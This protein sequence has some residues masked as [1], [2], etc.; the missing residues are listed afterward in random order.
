M[1][2]ALVSASAKTRA[3]LRRAARIGAHELRGSFLEVESALESLR[4][5]PPEL[6]VLEVGAIEGGALHAT[7]RLVDHVGCPLLLLARSDDRSIGEVSRALAAGAVD[8]VMLPGDAKAEQAMDAV[9]AKLRTM[10]RLTRRGCGSA[11]GT[12]P[13][14]REPLRGPAPLV[15]IGASTGGPQALAAVLSDLP[16]P[17]GG[18]VIAALHIDRA[19]GSALASWLGETAGLPCRFARGGER[20]AVGEVRIAAA[21]EHLVLGAD[22]ALDYRA[23]PSGALHRPSI[24]VLFGSLAEHA[25]GRGV[26]VLLTGM[27]R[28]G[29]QGLK[30]LR[31]R[32]WLTITQDEA[33]STVY[34]M[35]RA[36]AQIGAACRVLPLD[37]I[38]EAL[39]HAVCERS[40]PGS[41]WSRSGGG[42]G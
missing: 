9:V 28:D 21:D 12:E 18:A 4:E 25:V 16:R 38:G 41:R 5:D 7:K 36:A 37:R 35:P 31:A 15:A 10:R 22:G 42:S 3:L 13:G 40:G 30:A 17:F 26:A 11:A 14:A 1:R 27:G 2:I 23:E 8:V 29:A 6:L 20:P 39:G 34:G 24:D 33:S 32:G 19:F